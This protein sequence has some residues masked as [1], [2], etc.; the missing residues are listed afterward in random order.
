[1]DDDEII[2]DLI[3]EQLGEAGFRVSTADSAQ[4]A[5]S[6]IG[7][8]DFDVV[9]T[10]LK[11]PGMDG[12]GLLSEIRTIRPDMPVII[13][14]AF[15][16]VQT[17][18]QAMRAGALDYITKPFAADALLVVL[19]RAVERLELEEENRRLRRAVDRTASFGE[20]VGKSIAMNE[21]YSLIRKISHNRSN[22]LI[23]GESGTGKEVVAR[24]IHLTGARAE[25]PFIPINCT[26]MPEGL[27]E[28]ELF[29]HVRGAFTGANSAKKGLFEAA[30]T[31]TLFL[32]EIGDMPAS[33]QVKLLRV[34]QDQEIRPVGG[35]Y[36]VKVDVRVIAA[37]NQDMAARIESGQFRKDLYYRL[38]VIPIPIPPLRER[39][40]DIPPLAEAFLVRHSRGT[41]I[42]LSEKAM[43][44]L[45]ESPWEGNARELENCIERAVA[46]AEGP[47][48]KARDILLA[49]DPIRGSGDLEE[50]L[51]RLALQRRVSAHDLTELYIDAALRAARGR[52]SEAAR[53]LGMNRRTL[54]RREERLRR[55]EGGTRTES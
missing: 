26:A 42:R 13:M 25:K 51:F 33:L 15:G 50:G 1:V 20:L 27:L 48:I 21:I 14:T 28:S 53:S 45:Q 22:I 44:R 37:T 6:M 52:K 55:T 17:A 40:E 43:R 24:T 29:G 4:S 31:G 19:E 46:L 12:L 30:D 34:L 38:N 39:P 18:V 5:L 7:E 36:P 23:T 54:Y 8:A 11:M 32:D 10:D 49:D 47:I 3:T 9:L 41:P 16:S 35:N 2:R